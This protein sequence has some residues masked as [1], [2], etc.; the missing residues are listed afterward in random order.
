MICKIINN[1]LGKNIMGTCSIKFDFKNIESNSPFKYFYI[2][3]V[4]YNKI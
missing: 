4:K 1:R 3:G 2:G